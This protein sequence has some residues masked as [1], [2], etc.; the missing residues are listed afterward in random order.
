[1]AASKPKLIYIL[2]PSFSGSTLLTM[3]LAQHPRVATIGELKGTAMGR[4]EEYYCSCGKQIEQCDFWRQLT[5]SL[6]GEGLDFSLANFGT[7][8]G[9]VTPI[10]HRI[11]AAQIRGAWFERLR[12]LAI[13]LVPGLKKEF[14]RL[15]Q[16][17]YRAM[18]RIC[19]LQNGEFFLD[20]SK[21]PQR[22][23][24]FNESGK[25]D[26]YVI[27]MC[28]DGR[29]QCNSRRE[30][31]LEPVEFTGAVT[32]WLSTIRQMN[33]VVSKFSQGRVLTFK[34]EEFCLDP[35]RIIDQ[36]C[37]W[38]NID[39]LEVNWSSIDLK[40]SQHHIVGNRMRTR[41]RIVIKLDEAWRD[42]VTEEELTEFE[43]LAGHV[44][45]ALGY[46]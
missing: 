18:R 36:I 13:Q 17:N 11:L 43:R 28:R 34:Y 39:Q 35:N 21:D 15:L 6:A 45:R 8:F 24:Y 32:E 46:E 14:Q 29:A 2:S 44:N 1:M 30:K 42:K 23:L 22:L 25:F 9:A 12:K 33:Y 4:L 20:A 19:E 5:T 3:V 37:H 40:C 31:R 38:L 26:L 27:Q 7:H 16:Q 10:R 41:D